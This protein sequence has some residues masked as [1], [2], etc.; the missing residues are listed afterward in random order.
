M[1]LRDQLLASRVAED[2]GL[3]RK[4]AEGDEQQGG[5]KDG[6]AHVGGSM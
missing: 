2:F 4:Q 1:A 3:R 5:A 6:V